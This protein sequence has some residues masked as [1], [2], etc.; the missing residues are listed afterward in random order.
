[1]ETDLGNLTWQVYIALRAGVGLGT[2]R[3]L[4]E[5]NA[6]YEPP[7]LALADEK[8]YW[9]V[10]PNAAGAARLEDSL[11]RA[12]RLG[13]D[14]DFEKETPYTVLVS[15]GRMITNPLVSNGIVTFVPRVDTAN[16]Y[17]QLTALTCAQDKAVKFTVMPQSLRVSDALYLDDDFSFCIEN[18]YDYAEGLANFGTYY[19]LADGTYLRINKSPMS[20]PVRFNDCLIVKSIYNIVGIDLIKMKSFVLQAPTE[21][22]DFGEALIGWGVQEKVITC[23]LRMDKDI[24]GI[25]VLI[26]RVFG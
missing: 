23:S 17:Y 10:M 26:L 7:M 6:D 2:A 16:V 12:L 11:L 14:V 18:N 24:G 9:T 21:S 20:A 13:S 3:M 25:G 19:K 22:S 5:G 1:V 15:Q 8:A 4:E